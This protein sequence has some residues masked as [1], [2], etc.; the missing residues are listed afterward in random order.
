MNKWIVVAVLLPLVAC[1][2]NN[3]SDTSK[4]QDAQ[5]AK[6]VVAKTDPV[7][8]QIQQLGQES[9]YFDLDRSNV[10]NEYH[11]AIKHQAEFVKAHS[12]DTVTLAGNCDERGSAEYNL[13]L[14]DRRAVAVKKQLLALGVA[15]GQIKTVSNGKEN[16]RLACP[17]EK[18]W[19]ENRRVD[20]EHKLN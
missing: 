17:E 4:L 8:D 12:N 16:P 11:T 10:K 5:P 1:S 6:D 2:T 19:K 15:K 20:F 13:A 7:S 18:C 3:K 9:V 14:G